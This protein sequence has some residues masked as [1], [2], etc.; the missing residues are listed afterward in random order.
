MY[1]TA[2]RPSFSVSQMIPALPRVASTNNDVGGVQIRV[3]AFDSHV[4]FETSPDMKHAL[5]LL[6][7]NADQPSC[8]S[9]H[10]CF[11]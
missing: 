9:R 3:P 10:V 11:L 1:L 6:S 4:N 2:S 7:F 8:S 5:S